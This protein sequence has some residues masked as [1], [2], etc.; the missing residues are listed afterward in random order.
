MEIK[1]QITDIIYENEINGYMV[2]EFQTKDEDT[3]ITGCLPFINNGDSLKLI[4]KFIM[5]Q[6]YGRQ[7][8]VESFEKIMP[9]TTEGLEKYL[10]NGNIKGIGPAT[11]KKI[12]KLFGEETI[13]ILKYEP[14][15]LSQIKGI[16]KQKAIEISE[17]FIENWEVWQI[18]GFLERFKIGAENAKKVYD[19]FGTHAI[20]EIEANPYVLIDIARGVDFNQIDKMA[21]DLGIDYANSKRVKSGIKYALI[22]A[23][24]NGH[25]CTLKENLIDFVKQLLNV[26]EDTIDDNIIK[27]KVED[28]IIIETEVIDKGRFYITFQQFVKDEKSQK[29]YIEAMVKVVAIHKD[30]KLYRSLPEQ[31]EKIVQ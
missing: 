27:L 15:K 26:D 10:A 8:K 9:E 30:G 6:E 28:E 13:H 29:T 7:F 2:A 3:I 12:I 5:H 16:S 17:S 4:G 23:T 31:V 24:Y 1:G 25:C 22:K 18:V 21:L 20:E 19:L 14:D 11:A